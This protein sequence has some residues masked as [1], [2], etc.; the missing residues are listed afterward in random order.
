[1]PKPASSSKNQM[2]AHQRELRQSERDIQR[3][4]S[5][6][7]REEQKLQTQIKTAAKKGDTYVR[8]QNPKERWMQLLLLLLLFGLKGKEERQQ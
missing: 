1:M 7:D 3:E 6:M 5:R 2:R 4:I 8:V